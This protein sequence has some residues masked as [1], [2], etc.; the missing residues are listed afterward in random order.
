MTKKLIKYGKWYV[1][2]EI[3]TSFLGLGILWA[4]LLPV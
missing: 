2:Y 4:G 3:G 1:A